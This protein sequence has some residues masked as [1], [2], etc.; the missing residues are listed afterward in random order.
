MCSILH[1]DVVYTVASVIMQVDLFPQGLH[2]HLTAPAG[3]V[4]EH[5]A[6]AAAAQMQVTLEEG[7]ASRTALSMELVPALGL[8]HSTTPL[9][10]HAPQQSLQ[11]LPQAVAHVTA[12]SAV[13]PREVSTAS[14]VGGILSMPFSQKLS[15]FCIDNSAAPDTTVVL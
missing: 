4:L 10:A 5:L 9:P 6:F 3:S 12:A 2:L 11:A 13:L 15:L 7:I 8:G 14:T 1:S